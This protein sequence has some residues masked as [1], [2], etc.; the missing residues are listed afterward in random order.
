MVHMPRGKWARRSHIED[1]TTHAQRRERRGAR[2]GEGRE[3]ERRE[4]RRGGGGEGRGREQGSVR[5]RSSPSVWGGQ[6]SVGPNAGRTCKRITGPWG[7]LPSW[8]CCDRGCGGNITSRRRCGVK[9]QGK[10]IVE[11]TLMQAKC[12]GNE[13]GMGGGGV[14]EEPCEHTHAWPFGGFGE[15]TARARG[16]TQ[17]KPTAL[18][19]D[20]SGHHGGR[21]LPCYRMPTHTQTKNTTN[22]KQASP[23]WVLGSMFTHAAEGAGGGGGGGRAVQHATTKARH[24]KQGPSA[25]LVCGGHRRR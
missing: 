20:A 10:Q 18:A 12:K 9:G 4:R 5:T 23:T 21:H 17:A 19:G 13:M 6:V 16:T 11:Q 1:E 14:L 2:G 22:H 15:V 25:V 24:T 8:L 3:R 7:W